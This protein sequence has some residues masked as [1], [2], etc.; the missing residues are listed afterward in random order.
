MNLGMRTAWVVIVK[1]FPTNVSR[2]VLNIAPGAEI[3]H[4][5]AKK[6]QPG[7]RTE[8][9]ARAGIRHVIGPWN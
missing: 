3:R 7:G 8:I 4:V 5:I 1:R 2:P 6:F 9:S